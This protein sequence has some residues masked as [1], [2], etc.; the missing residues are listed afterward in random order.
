MSRTIPSRSDTEDP[1]LPEGCRFRF[2]TRA[3]LEIGGARICFE[4]RPAILLRELLNNHGKRVPLPLLWTAMI[5]DGGDIP[6]TSIA[7]AVSRELSSLFYK[8]SSLGI[9]MTVDD[10]QPDAGIMLSAVT[11]VPQPAS[12]QGS[13]A[14][15]RRRQTRPV[16]HEPDARPVNRDPNTAA[17]PFRERDGL[18]GVSHA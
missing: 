10:S 2:W 7:E 14:R 11:L 16:T 12:R 9:L 17:R 15:K 18:P 5:S 1:T 6:A 13:G 4:G 8:L 3:E